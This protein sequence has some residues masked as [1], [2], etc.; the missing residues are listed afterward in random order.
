MARKYS[1]NFRYNK[2][3]TRTGTD[4]RLRDVWDQSQQVA[5]K[6]QTSLKSKLSEWG[7]IIL[8]FTVVS[9]VIFCFVLPRILPT[10]PIFRI[11]AY[12]ATFKTWLF[13]MG[14][15]AL[16]GLIYDLFDLYNYQASV[17]GEN[18]AREML[19]HD[20]NDA[21]IEQPE[22]LAKLY[23]IAPDNKVHFDVDVTNLLSHVMLDNSGVKGLDGKVHFDKAFGQKL[24]DVA[25]L[26]QSDPPRIFYKPNKLL[27]NPDKTFGKNEGKTVAD[28]INLTWH[29]PDYEDGSQDPAGAYIVSTAPENTVIA[30]ETR[31]GKG[32]KYIE[33]I[34]DVWSRQNKLPNII[35]TDLKMELL[36]KSLKTFTYRGYNVRSLNLLVDSKTDAIN[37]IG[38]ACDAAVRGD[39]TK[40]EQLTANIAD[41][42]FPKGDGGQDP[43]WNN[44]AST[45]F[46]R[47]TY[48]LIDFYHE[49]VRRLGRDMSLTPTQVAQKSDEAYG[50]VTLYN[51]Y[52][53][54]VETAASTFNSSEIQK[55]YPLD[56]NGLPIDPDPESQTKSGLTVYFDA[57]ASLPQNAIREKI[58]NQ[59]KALKS[60]AK[61]EKM[62]AS[63]YGICLFGMIFFTDNKVIK[64][65]SARPSQNLDIPGF[66]F[67]RRLAVRLADQYI[68]DNDLTAKVCV[69]SSYHDPQM[70]KPYEGKGFTY[71]TTV[72]TYGWI[73]AYFSGIFDN[74]PVYLKLD[75]YNASGYEAGGD[76]NLLLQTYRFVF[77]KDYRKTYSGREYAINPVTGEREI[78]GGRMQEYELVDGKVRPFQTTYRRMEYDLTLPKVQAGEADGPKKLLDAIK[79]MSDE[80][81]ARRRKIVRKRVFEVYDIHYTEKPT[82][83]FLVAPPSTASYNK[84][85]LITIDMVYNQQVDYSYLGTAKQKPYYSTKYLLDEFGNM[86]SEGH[87]VSGLDTKLSSGLSAE[88]Q[89]TLILQSMKQ[90]ETIYGEA[91]ATT[92]SANVGKFM[93]MKSKDKTLIN[94]LLDMNGKKH[95][96][97]ES[98]VGY[99]RPM[100]GM[101][102]IT[103]K[104]D[105]TADKARANV[106]MS[107]DER[108]VI[109]EN[110]YL[111]LNDEAADG[112]A[113]VSTGG[114]PIWSQAQT[115]MPMSFALLPNRTGGDGSDVSPKNMPTMADTTEFD[116]LSNLPNFRDMTLARIKE[117]SYAQPVR[118]LYKKVHG[119]S[120]YDL[121]RQNADVVAD[122]I[123]NGIDDNIQI[124]INNAPTFG[125]SPTLGSSSYSLRLQDMTQQLAS[126]AQDNQEKITQN[127]IDKAHKQIDSM[128]DTYKPGINTD[129]LNIKIDKDY[130]EKMTGDILKLSNDKKFAGGLLS[131]T[132][133][134][135][136]H[137]DGDGN[138][139]Y[140]ADFGFKN[141]LAEALDELAGKGLGMGLAW[142]GKNQLN[143]NGDTVARRDEDGDWDID[144]KLVVYLAQQ[145]HWSPVLDQAIAVIVRKQHG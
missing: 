8:V 68:K 129:K 91:T 118:E 67:P 31:A 22:N 14:V 15:G 130:E 23:D 97:Q 41:I 25:R 47:T 29:V 5:V 100:G 32:Q 52:K 73:D 144:N 87:G 134:A 135:S 65:T 143:L 137:K 46:K 110:D 101:H 138:L 122:D 16:G 78:Q 79:N 19:A 109:S 20:F 94:M 115:I 24:Y 141:T 107:R 54:V 18:T 95:V 81:I 11:F 86:Q 114:N 26:P 61:S 1:D 136:V 106:N 84:I 4:G 57:T 113:I 43:M 3:N 133:V 123:M 131:T 102:T 63:I 69:W 124:G 34:L 74:K 128:P 28:T 76:H 10:A 36:K 33:P 6:P 111:R 53:F 64:L 142:R 7:F 37:F 92:L 42:Y 108:P 90:L 125:G 98:S 120:D 75:I 40:M 66:A 44:A 99:D 51:A 119:W 139:E 38:Y 82:A 71:E 56:D 49:E 12:K 145:P 21:Y 39:V 72:D 48:G 121:L 127:E 83:L 9:V 132:N 96:I 140:I 77:H 70:T 30:A 17:F 105:E 85:L 116:P 27:Y 126:L 93:F 60:S 58:A 45:V 80:E 59:D 35:A 62:M 104:K 88:Q 13:A 112:N 103:F 89:F 117:A 55:I 50:H 2:S